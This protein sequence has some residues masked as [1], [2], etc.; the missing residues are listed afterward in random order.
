M[1]S[2][3]QHEHWWIY[4]STQHREVRTVAS[5]DG[6]FVA[7]IC[8]RSDGMY[9]FYVDRLEYVAESEV[10]FWQPGSLETGLFGTS[11]EAETEARSRYSELTD[12]ACMPAGS[13]SA[14]SLPPT[15]P[16]PK[17]DHLRES[18]SVKNAQKR[19]GRFR[20]YSDAQ[21]GNPGSQ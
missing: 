2:D 7:A 8:Q 5:E 1:N 4:R 14:R 17:L 6:R 19:P 16:F 9:C 3:R 10:D 18:R 13:S 11:D 21:A 15:Q 20:P 12:A